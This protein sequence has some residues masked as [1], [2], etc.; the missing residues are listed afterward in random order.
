MICGYGKYS[1]FIKP[2]FN[3]SLEPASVLAETF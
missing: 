2:L 1:N 3:L